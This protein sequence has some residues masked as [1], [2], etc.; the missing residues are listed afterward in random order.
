MNQWFLLKVGWVL[1]GVLMSIPCSIIVLSASSPSWIRAIFVIAGLIYWPV[2]WYAFGLMAKG[3]VSSSG[4]GEIRHE[5]PNYT[6][7]EK[8]GRLMKTWLVGR[9]FP[10]PTM[11]KK[12]ND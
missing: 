10:E 2:G 8:S 1:F 11:L 4:N 5:N 3:Y 9:N 12:P 7:Y 6:D